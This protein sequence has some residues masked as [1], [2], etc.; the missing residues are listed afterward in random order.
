M[1]VHCRLLAAV[2]PDN[3][4]ED[5]GYLAYQYCPGRHLLASMKT[6]SGRRIHVKVGADKPQVLPKER[7]LNTELRSQAPCI[8]PETAIT[9]IAAYVAIW[10]FLALFVAQSFQSSL[11]SLVTLFHF[12]VYL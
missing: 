9:Y 2:D 7:P 10:G 6:V 8:A 4:A 11:W 5:P 12:W 3:P 1:L